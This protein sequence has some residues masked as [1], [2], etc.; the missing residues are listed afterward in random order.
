M[1]VNEANEAA[2]VLKDYPEMH[3]ANSR[4]CDRKAHRDA[5]AESMTIFETQNDKAQQ[6]IEALVKEVIL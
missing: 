1:F 3:L 6:E 2:E 4:V 5:W